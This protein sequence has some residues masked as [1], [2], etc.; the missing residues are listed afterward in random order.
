MACLLFNQEN[1]WI[2]KI[3]PRKYAL[4]QRCIVVYEICVCVNM[5]W[6]AQYSVHSSVSISFPT[7]HT[8]LYILQHRM[9]VYTVQN[10]EGDMHSQKKR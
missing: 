3:E 5:N 4:D 1:K 6:N 10:W 9:Y 2:D 8:N 7:M